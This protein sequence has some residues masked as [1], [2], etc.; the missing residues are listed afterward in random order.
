MGGTFGTSMGMLIE[1][2]ATLT[3]WNSI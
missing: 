2:S 1:I 3:V